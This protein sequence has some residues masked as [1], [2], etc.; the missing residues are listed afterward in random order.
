MQYLGLRYDFDLTGV[1]I[2]HQLQYIGCHTSN[3]TRRVQG[4]F[5]ERPQRRPYP[6]L[7]HESKGHRSYSNADFLVSKFITEGSKKTIS[8]VEPRRT[9]ANIRIAHL[10][11]QRPQQLIQWKL[12]TGGAKYTRSHNWNIIIEINIFIIWIIS[13]KMKDFAD[14]ISSLAAIIK[15]FRWVSPGSYLGDKYWESEFQIF[16]TITFQNISSPPTLT[17]RK[18]P[19]PK[20]SE[21]MIKESM[22]NIEPKVIFKVDQ[23]WRWLSPLTTAAAKG[24]K[25]WRSTQWCK[26]E[27]KRQRN[28]AIWDQETAQLSPPSDQAILISLAFGLPRS[29]SQLKSQ[30]WRSSCQAQSHCQTSG[31]E[32]TILKT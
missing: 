25:K 13:I 30:N 26:N 1:H 5:P 3:L 15:Y 14:W 8:F 11:I 20:K 32:N 21:K 7:D 2:A 16:Q 19:N 4:M 31:W 28:K 18:S 22:I 24:G 27:A 12:R 29:I 6:S 17:L 23:L 10:R 9:K